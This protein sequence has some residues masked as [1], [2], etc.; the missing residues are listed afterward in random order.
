MFCFIGTRFFFL[1]SHSCTVCHFLPF[2]WEY[3]AS[4]L[5]ALLYSQV[6]APIDYMHSFVSCQAS[7][8]SVTLFAKNCVDWQCSFFWVVGL[9]QV[10]YNTNSSFACFMNFRTSSSVFVTILH[11]LCWIGRDQNGLYFFVYIHVYDIY[12]R[13]IVSTLLLN[14]TYKML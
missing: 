10:R 2:W 12:Q 11:F 8:Y 1:D 6:G 5:I 3:L 13:I 14:V 4:A 7:S 9:L